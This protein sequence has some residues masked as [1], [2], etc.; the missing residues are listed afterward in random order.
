MMSQDKKL[1]AARRLRSLMFGGGGMEGRGTGAVLC[2]L[3]SGTRFQ[4]DMA[5]RLTT[6]Q[7]G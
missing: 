2:R 1:T 6:T 5:V 3:T 4:A 7:T